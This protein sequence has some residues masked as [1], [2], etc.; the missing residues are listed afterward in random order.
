MYTKTEN[1]LF[2]LALVAL[3]ATIGAELLGSQ[4]L[5]TVGVGVFALAVVA[6]FA[7]MSVVLA[8]GVART[9]D[10]NTLDAAATDRPR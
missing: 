7:V 8:V 9:S 10:Q 2:G 3:S 1:Q 4:L 6:L 5:V